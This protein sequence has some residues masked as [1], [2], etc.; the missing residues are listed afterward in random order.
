MSVMRKNVGKENGAVRKVTATEE[1]CFD[2]LQKQEASFLKNVQTARGPHPASHSILIVDSFPSTKRPG[3]EATIRPVQCRNY[4][5]REL[6][7]YYH[8]YRYDKKGTCILRNT[9]VY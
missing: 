8:I 2:W 5:S 7:L 4:E 3:R 6:N 1:L 9:N